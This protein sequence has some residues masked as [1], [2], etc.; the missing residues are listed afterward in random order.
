MLA[1]RRGD[2]SRL[3]PLFDRYHRPL[4]DYLVRMTGNR[5]AAEDLVQ[6][7]FVRILKYRHTFRHDSRFDTW[8]FRIARNARVDY[9]QSRRARETA[10]E[11]AAE[12]ADAAAG[13]AE[14]FERHR[15]SA[16]VR[17]ALMLLR[18][19]QRELIVLARYRGMKYDAIADLLGIEVGAVKVRMHRAVKE[20]RDIFLRL[21]E[22]PC[23]AKQ[24]ANGLLMV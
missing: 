24:P 22:K 6:D 15:D 14:Q 13:A 19:D 5:A 4:F 11:D 12:P 21:S 20:L 1:V 7:V 9:F 3:E 17:R 23:S 16:A 2:L 10:L 8:I 18:D